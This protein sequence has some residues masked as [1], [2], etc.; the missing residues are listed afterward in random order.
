VTGA[1]EASNRIRLRLHIDQSRRLEPASTDCTVVGTLLSLVQLDDHLPDF[2]VLGG[3][4]RPVELGRKFATP[5]VAWPRCRP[6]T[7]RCRV[8]PAR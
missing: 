2:L 4:V 1:A 6:G 8:A 7:A 3:E 5:L